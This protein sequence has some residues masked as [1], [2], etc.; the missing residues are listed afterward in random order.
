[1]GS[2]K[3]GRYEDPG[4]LVITFAQVRIVLYHFTETNYVQVGSF[5]G[6]EHKGAPMGDALSCAILRLFKWKRERSTS[7]A[8]QSDTIRF[9]GCRSQ[10]ALI[11]G[12]QVWVLDVSFR[13]DVRIF[14]CWGCPSSLCTGDV[15]AWASA[16][17]RR[18]FQVGSMIMESTDPSLFTGLST[19]WSEE[20]LQLS[21]AFLDPWAAATYNDRD[22]CPLKPWLSWSPRA[23]KSAVIRSMLCRCWYQS[24]ASGQRA[25]AI[26]QALLL[27]VLRANFPIEFAAS[28]A[29]Q[30]A[31]S[32]VPRGLREVPPSNLRDVTDALQRLAR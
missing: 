9:P 25:H 18:R 27:I 23:Q 10:L 19:T 15:H 28:V 3:L 21:P 6:R 1:M 22:N 7:Q 31:K 5:L 2:G 8:E 16:R 32:W 14:A 30:W 26:W 24:N 17:L 29:R 20:G 12:V 11:K 13:D 4:W